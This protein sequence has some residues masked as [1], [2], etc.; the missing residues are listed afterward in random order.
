[1]EIHDQIWN[2]HQGCKNSWY[3]NMMGYI[4]STLPESSSAEEEK[5]AFPGVCPRA[6]MM[7]WPKNRWM[8]VIGGEKAM[9]LVMCVWMWMCRLG[10]AVSQRVCVCVCVCVRVCCVCV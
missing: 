2:P 5:R 10:L 3:E 6:A 4:G 9:N 7:G 8:A 1:M